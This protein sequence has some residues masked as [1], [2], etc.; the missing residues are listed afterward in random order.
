MRLFRPENRILLATLV[1]AVLCLFLPFVA[2]LLDPSHTF[3]ERDI[4]RSFLP[5]K[6]FWLNTL[7]TEHAL[8]TWN[9]FV[10]SGTPYWADLKSGVLNPF[11]LTL[12]FFSP[13]NIYYAF[14]WFIFVHFL[15]AA[16]GMFFCLRALAFEKE[17][18]LPFG[19]AYALSGTLI[20]SICMPNLLAG[21]AVLPYFV[22]FLLKRE[23]APIEILGPTSFALMAC[24]AIPLYCATPEFTYFFALA[25]LV[26]WL[27]KPG[28]NSFASLACIGAGAFAL[29]AAQLLPAIETFLHTRRF[30]NS[31]SMEESNHYSFHLG[32]IREIFLMLP[33]G[34]YEPK[35]IHWGEMYATT[36]FYSPYVGAGL[37]IAVAALLPDALRKYRTRAAAFTL[38][39]VA[40]LFLSFGKFFPIDF[41]GLL[42]NYFPGWKLFRS[43]EKMLILLGFLLLL[44]Q[45]KGWQ[46][47]LKHGNEANKDTKLRFAA[48]GF[49]FAAVA[50][51][52][53]VL[54]F[55]NEAQRQI[56]FASL[57]HFYFY[58][59]LMI[60]LL[61]LLKFFSKA[62]P[63][64]WLLLL[65]ILGFDLGI[66]ARALMWDEPVAALQSNTL[67]KVKVDLQK[68]ELEIKNGA[69]FRYSSLPVVDNRPNLRTLPNVKLDTIGQLAQSVAFHVLPAFTMLH[70]LYDVS[71]AGALPDADRMSLWR[72]LSEKNPRRLL[73]LLGA[74]YVVEYTTRELSLKGNLAALPYLFVPEE[75]FF[76]LN[77]HTIQDAL[78]SDGFREHTQLALEGPE[79]WRALNFR[80]TA[81]WI[82]KNTDFLR[83][84]IKETK[85][86]QRHILSLGE[87]YDRHWHAAVNGIETPILL[88]NGWAMAVDLGPNCA[89][90][91][92]LEL[93]YFNPWIPLGIAVTVIFLAAMLLL[94]RRARRTKNP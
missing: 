23:K 14:S 5:G 53:S 27:R 63:Y 68:R 94:S 79:T 47:L 67:T 50:L 17:S 48:G 51:T 18:A 43:P 19:V 35:A 3:V 88:A 15:V 32:R 86:A 21:Q 65:V 38:L 71:G 2:L 89:P 1:C 12:L 28:R 58:G 33:F 10:Y 85:G 73:N 78:L 66:H 6:F 87:S 25:L 16:A 7:R 13:E 70:G 83:I 20:S 81:E 26:Q 92:Q 8:P 41:Y 22:A 57:R 60:C 80:A 31:L 56:G 34:N 36:F 90:E 62:R 82:E 44:A 37:P 29:T 69:A 42:Y 84:R 46:L 75:L 59:G 76:F 11:H 52:A 64:R 74:H 40:A 9:P 93:R 55:P 54:V 77:R 30:V 91:C 49:L 39:A 45:A 61:A 72:A 4:L 24:L